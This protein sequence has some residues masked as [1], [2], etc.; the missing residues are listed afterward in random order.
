MTAATPTASPGAAPLT[1]VRVH[2]AFADGSSWSGVIERL[3]AQGTAVVAPADSLRGITHDSA[4]TAS[5]I[6]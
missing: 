2:G 1:V 4:Y 3:Q 6:S 5:R